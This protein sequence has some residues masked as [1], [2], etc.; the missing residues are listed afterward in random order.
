MR[1]FNIS[2]ISARRI[3]DIIN[4][5]NADVGASEIYPPLNHDERG[6]YEHLIDLKKEMLKA[7]PDVPALFENVEYDYDDP[8]LDIY[9]DTVDEMAAG[10]KK[11]GK[12]K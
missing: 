7:Y 11:G 12:V 8:L 10:W 4:A 3:N 5:V 9:S 2:S 6:Y 1:K